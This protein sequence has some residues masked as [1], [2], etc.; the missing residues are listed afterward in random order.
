MLSL[1]RNIEAIY[2]LEH[3]LQEKKKLFRFESG[4]KVNEEK[5]IKLLRNI[6][7]AKDNVNITID[8]YDSLRNLKFNPI[9]LN[10][11][12]IKKQDKLNEYNELLLQKNPVNLKIY[13]F[14]K[15]HNELNYLDV[16]D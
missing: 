9:L 16:T 11:C 1:S 7:K 10:R 15:L 14:E 3:H 8:L 2:Y 13:D 4:Q 5:L 12:L 6:Q